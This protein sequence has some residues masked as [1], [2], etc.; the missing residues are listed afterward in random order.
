MAISDANVLAV[1]APERRC[2]MSGMH[3]EVG[4]KELYAPKIPKQPRSQYRPLCRAAC[5]QFLGTDNTVDVVSFFLLSS[6]PI[7]G[8]GYLEYLWYVP[9]GG[10]YGCR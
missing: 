8:I 4:Q 7:L 10:S 2:G 9:T 1:N 6:A 5:K 3:S